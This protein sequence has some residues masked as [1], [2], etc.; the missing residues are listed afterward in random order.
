MYSVYILRC[1][2]GSF[3]VGHSQNVEARVRAH[4]EGAASVHTKGRGPLTI[5]YQEPHATERAA[6]ARERQLKRWTHAKK[7]ALIQGD[8]ADLN[9]LSRS[10]STRLRLDTP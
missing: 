7:A 1:G 6:V 5:V 4:A 2:D 9:R 10:T 3:Y 8:L